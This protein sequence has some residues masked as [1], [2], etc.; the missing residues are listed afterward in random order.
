MQHRMTSPPAATGAASH[1]PQI[2]QPWPLR[3]KQELIRIS[4]SRKDK[5]KAATAKRWLAEVNGVIFESGRGQLQLS[6][7]GQQRMQGKLSL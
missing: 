4:A 5:L 1:R 6:K 2:G 3:S 7:S